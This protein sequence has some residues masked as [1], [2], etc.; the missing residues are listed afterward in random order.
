[1]EET[2]LKC[3]NNIIELGLVE[4]T[5]LWDTR[6]TKPISIWGYA[7]NVDYNDLLKLKASDDANEIII[8]NFKE[9]IN[10]EMS[11]LHS[12]WLLK[13]LEFKF[14][15]GIKKQKIKEKIEFK[16]YLIICDKLLSNEIRKDLLNNKNTHNISDLIKEFY[17]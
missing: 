8:V 1:M 16:K 12:Y 7:I 3:F 11:F 15:S 9:L 10:K 17:K 5:L 4:N 13:F 14:V 6:F 2:G